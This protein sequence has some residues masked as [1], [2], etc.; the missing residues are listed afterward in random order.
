MASSSKFK[1]QLDAQKIE[2]DIKII[3]KSVGLSTTQ[4]N[5]ANFSGRRW[6]A[7]SWAQ[8][9][10][11]VK[12]RPPSPPAMQGTRNTKTQPTVTA[13]KHRVVTVK[14][15]DHGIAQQ[16]RIH[17]AAWIR[18]Q[19]ETSMHKCPTGKNHLV[20]EELR[21]KYRPIVRTG[22]EEL[23]IFDPSVLPLTAVKMTGPMLFGMI[24]FFQK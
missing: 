23:T 18:Q 22:P 3:K 6:A 2:K 4:P 8:V 19:V 16:Y 7:T 21:E 5:A 20:F 15:K 12:H 14:L 9:A 11:Q 24:S 1:T 17:P 10:A 13:Y